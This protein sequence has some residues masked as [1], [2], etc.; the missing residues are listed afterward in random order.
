MTEKLILET[1]FVAV[2]CWS[3]WCESVH[4]HCACVLWE[5]C[6]FFIVNIHLDYFIFWL[7]IMWSFVIIVL[8]T[9]CHWPIERVLFISLHVLAYNEPEYGCWLFGWPKRCIYIYYVIAKA[10]QLN[11]NSNL[12]NPSQPSFEK[13]DILDKNLQGMDG[14]ERYQSVIQIYTPDTNITGGTNI[15]SEWRLL[16]VTLALNV[17]VLSTRW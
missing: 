1:C 7:H 10:C 14:K 9:P 6:V 3:W 15:C 4:M 2:F 17:R 16:I 8:L 5:L 13:H 12:Y 11:L